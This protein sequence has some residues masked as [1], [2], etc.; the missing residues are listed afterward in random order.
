MRRALGDTKATRSVC[1]RLLERKISSLPLWEE[2]PRKTEPMNGDGASM[3]MC[4]IGWKCVC[5]CVCLHSEGGGAQV[6]VLLG[7]QIYNSNNICFHCDNIMAVIDS[8]PL[9]YVN[10]QLMLQ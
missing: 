4:T 5:V 1:E 3:C 9:Y 10:T 2:V 8:V 6:I 7:I